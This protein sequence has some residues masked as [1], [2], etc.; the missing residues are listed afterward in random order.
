MSLVQSGKC[1]IPAKEGAGILRIPW[2]MPH[3]NKPPGFLG[4]RE[5]SNTKKK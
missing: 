3:T 4:L 1:S 2:G 5:T